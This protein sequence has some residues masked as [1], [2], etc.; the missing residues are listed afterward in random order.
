VDIVSTHP[1]VG[2]RPPV[3]GAG[4]DD[5]GLPPKEAWVTVATAVVT[6]IVAGLLMWYV[7]S[8]P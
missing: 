2:K 5:G 6:L 8:G 1:D 7:Q 3:P 4:Y